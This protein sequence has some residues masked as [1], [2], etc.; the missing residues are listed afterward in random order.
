VLFASNTTVPL[1]ADLVQDWSPQD[2]DQ[3]KAGPRFVRSAFLSYTPIQSSD[4]GLQFV[5]RT[6]MFSPISTQPET[7]SISATQTVG[8]GVGLFVGLCVAA[9]G[10]VVGFLVGAGVVGEEVGSGVIVG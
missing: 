8:L 5:N 10:F 6:S 9:V 4:L 3:S 1:L 2:Q 7:Y